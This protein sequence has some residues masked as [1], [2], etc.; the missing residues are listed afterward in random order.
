[1]L[2]DAATLRTLPSIITTSMPPGLMACNRVGSHCSRVG[3]IW[4]AV[5]YGETPVWRL[6][7]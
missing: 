2:T 7:G 6:I 3:V 5:M 4:I 1:M